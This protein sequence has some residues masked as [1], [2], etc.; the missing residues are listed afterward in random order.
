MLAFR[1]M[2]MIALLQHLHDDCR[3]CQDETCPCHEGNGSRLAKPHSNRHQRHNTGANLKC[4]EAEYILAH[5][6]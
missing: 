2:Q 3:R 6:P 5:A 4:A 1:C